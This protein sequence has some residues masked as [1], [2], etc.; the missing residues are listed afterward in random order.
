MGLGLFTAPQHPPGVVPDDAPTIAQ[1]DHISASF[2]WANQVIS[3][4]FAEGVTFLGY[5]ALSE[6]AQRPE[7]RVISE[8][9]ATEMTREW[10]ELKSTGSDDKTEK[11]KVLSE[12][13]ENFGVRDAFRHIAEYDGFMG[14]AHLYIDTGKTDDR[15]E[16]KTPLGNGRDLIS[17]SKVAKGS[18]KAFRPVEAVWCYPTHYDSN[19]PLKPDWYDP[20]RWFVMGKEVHR[21]RLLTFI[22][23][24]VPDML[25]PAYSFGG[26]SLSQMARPYVDNWLRTRQSVSDLVHS[27]SVF[28]LSTDLNAWLSAG[29]DQLDRRVA[30]FNNYRDNRGLMLL[31]KEKETFQNVSAQVAGL[32]HIQAQSQE[33]MAAVSRIPL[34][35]L[36]GITPSGL[37]ASSDGEIRVFENTIHSYQERLFRK[38]LTTVI[39]FVQLHLWGE[40]DLDIGFV[41]KL[42][43]QLDEQARSAVEKTKTDIDDVNVAMGSVSPEEVRRRVATDPGSQYIG[44]D[45][46]PDEMP[47]PPAEGGEEPPPVEGGEEGLQPDE[48]VVSGR[49]LLTKAR[50]HLNSASGLL[51]LARE[52]LSNEGRR[53][54]LDRLREHLSEADISL[55]DR[56]RDHLSAA[57]VGLLDR[58]REHLQGGL[59]DQAR[60]ALDVNS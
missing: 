32:D 26:L 4:A 31:D 16:L 43:R 37:N 19:D 18:I 34:I 39:D 53:G 27:F 55:L 13:L 46:D 59:L 48:G 28:A 3:S 33:H 10:I 21:S 9:I 44:L 47:E 7:Y 58:A 54:L 40:I 20:T 42:L 29:G 5:A 49:E 35:Y 22:G 38:K 50:G 57:E 14:R 8:T 36:T 11:I 2:G 60:L 24:E 56:A 52:R 12:A 17:K 1:D 45:L 25:K 41:F 23:R 30:V 6:M 51:D 15:D